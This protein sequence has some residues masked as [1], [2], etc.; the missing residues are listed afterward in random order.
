MAE[1]MEIERKF[2]MDGLPAE[3]AALPGVLIEQGFLN[4]DKRRTTRIRV[5]SEGEAFLT[6]KGLSQ[7]A[8]RKEFETAIDAE[9]AKGMLTMVEGAVISKTRRKVDFAGKTWEVDE[10]HGENAGLVMAE[11]ELESEDEAFEKPAWALEEVT[12]D[13]RY[14][15]SSLALSPVSSWPKRPSPKRG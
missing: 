8:S 12:E 5:T 1:N 2:L 11:I 7:G 6:V 9:K 15:N 13:P 4:P 14:A 10:F 3:L